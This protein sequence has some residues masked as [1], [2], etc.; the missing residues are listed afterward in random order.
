MAWHLLEVVKKPERLPPDTWQEFAAGARQLWRHHAPSGYGWRPTLKTMQQRLVTSTTGIRLLK[1][2]IPLSARARRAM[3][4]GYRP[5][6][7]L[8]ANP[9]DAPI[10]SGA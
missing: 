9:D 2:V 3:G 5:W 7:R 6:E 8:S 10:N 1:L 4:L